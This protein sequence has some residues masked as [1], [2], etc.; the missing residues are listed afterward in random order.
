MEEPPPKKKKRGRPPNPENANK[1]PKPKPE[2]EP[3]ATFQCD[4][5][6][7]KFKYEVTLSVHVRIYHE[8]SEESKCDFCDNDFKKKSELIRHMMAVHEKQKVKCP[9]C[10]RTLA[11]VSQMKMHVRSEHKDQELDKI[12]TFGLDLSGNYACHVCDDKFY[13]AASLSM[14]LRIQHSS[15]KDN[16]FDCDI[17]LEE[18]KNKSDLFKHVK[19]IHENPES[20]KCVLCG[21]R[22]QSRVIMEDHLARGH[23]IYS[24][25]FKTTTAK[26]LQNVTPESKELAEDEPY[27]T[28]DSVPTGIEVLTPSED[29]E[30][31][32]CDE[33]F[34]YE[35]S[36]NIHKR[37]EHQPGNCLFCFCDFCDR[38]FPEKKHL[39]RHFLNVHE[40][41]RLYCSGC[42][43]VYLTKKKQAAHVDPVKGKCPGATF[44]VGNKESDINVTVKNLPPEF[45][46][47]LL[48]DNCDDQFRHAGCLKMHVR[49]A[50]ENSQDTKC[51]LCDKTY[52]YRFDLEKHFLGVH[53]ARSYTCKLCGYTLKDRSKVGH[54]IKNEHGVDLICQW[55]KKFFESKASLKNHIETD[56]I[57]KDL[58]THDCTICDK[59]YKTMTGLKYHL[60]AE[61]GIEVGSGEIP[62]LLSEVIVNYPCD[63]CKDV[64]KI[65]DSLKLHKKIQ[66]MDYSKIVTS[67]TNVTEEEEEKLECCEC[68]A[69]FRLESSLFM[70]LRLEHEGDRELYC[71]ECKDGREYTSKGALVKHFLRKHERQPVKCH[72][73]ETVYTHSYQLSAHYFNKH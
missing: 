26:M 12:K 66:H 25:M 30:C 62:E 13:L 69:T 60:N 53:E 18:F 47:W 52:R 65:Q 67:V 56:H 1:P 8:G 49:L 24:F 71:D 61:H 50:H 70:H 29:F 54:H 28:T 40:R 15:E 73:C 33:A 46:K 32:L 6:N 68:F 41:R 37:L 44:Y 27:F 63:Q 36:L 43:N 14:H 31:D 3:E 51:D 57:Q 55:C 2:P 64:F 19:A 72:I 21:G 17:C 35:K 7:E 10:D 34:H 38:E 48:C 45:S 9:F 5:C 22:F 42:R 58:K 11:K 59:K 23:S 20:L 4:Q 39:Q 16:N